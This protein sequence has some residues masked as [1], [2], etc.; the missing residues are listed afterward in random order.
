MI[1]KHLLIWDNVTP[2]CS[3][4]LMKVP[5]FGSLHKTGSRMQITVVGESS[6]VDRQVAA[7]LA[8]AEPFGPPTENQPI[9]SETE[10]QVFAAMQANEVYQAQ[11]AELDL[12]VPDNGSK[13]MQA[14]RRTALRV[15]KQKQPAE[16]RLPL[17]T[18]PAT[19]VSVAKPPSLLRKLYD[20]V[21]G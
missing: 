11:I 12:M 9:G 10:P 21:W 16:L 18:P 3:Q 1:I 13:M 5:F 8:A 2:E 19:P 14:V 20:K 4:S 7:L 15:I 6:T 17:V